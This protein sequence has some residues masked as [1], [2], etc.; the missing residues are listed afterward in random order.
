M[1]SQSTALGHRQQLSLLIPLSSS[2]LF[3]SQ[4]LFPSIPLSFH[5]FISSPLFSQTQ[6]LLTAHYSTNDECLSLCVSD[7]HLLEAVKNVSM[8][9]KHSSKLLVK[10]P[11]FEGEICFEPIG[12]IFSNGE[13]VY[14]FKLPKCRRKTVKCEE[15]A[16]LISGRFRYTSLTANN[17]E[18]FFTFVFFRTV[19]SFSVL[20]LCG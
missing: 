16:S 1:F 11:C 12:E 3:L 5:A 17:P 10:I 7:S 4:S 14:L 15:T 2:A 6:A 19:S 8:K 13:R 18:K 9:R 20:C